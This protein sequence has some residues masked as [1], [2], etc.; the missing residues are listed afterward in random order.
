MLSLPLNTIAYSETAKAFYRLAVT[1]TPP[2]RR[3]ITYPA[4]EGCVDLPPD[5]FYLEITCGNE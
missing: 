4:G 1:D 3:W 2:G 5:T